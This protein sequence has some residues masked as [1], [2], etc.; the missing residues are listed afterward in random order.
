MK[1]SQTENIDELRKE[2]V[3]RFHAKRKQIQTDHIP[4][5]GNDSFLNSLLDTLEAV[6]Q[7]YYNDE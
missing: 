3:E 1:D 2:T 5:M 6:E 7:G 4:P